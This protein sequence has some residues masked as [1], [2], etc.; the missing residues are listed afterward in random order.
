MPV[1][2]IA[3][4]ADVKCLEEQQADQDNDRHPRHR[5]S[6]DDSVP[7]PA[8]RQQSIVL[9]QRAAV[10]VVGHHGASPELIREVDGS[11]IAA[12]SLFSKALRRQ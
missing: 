7:E 12:V 10:H 9:H 6:N 2:P 11:R 3:Q 1:N 8:V 5:V 4:H